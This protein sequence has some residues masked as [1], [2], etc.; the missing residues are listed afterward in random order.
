MKLAVYLNL[1]CSYFHL[2]GAKSK[3]DRENFIPVIKSIRNYYSTSPVFILHWTVKHI[4][5]DDLEIRH[6]LFTWTQLLQREGI[7]TITT[8]IKNI[9]VL[10]E[11]SHSLRPLIILFIPGLDAMHEF[12]NSSKS[13][14]MSSF[15]WLMIFVPT[16]MNK[17]RNYCKHP[18]KNLFNLLFDTE[19]LTMCYNDPIFREWYSVDG[20]NI[21]TYD[22]MKV[23]AEGSSSQ[24][25][26]MLTNLSL[27]ER[28]NNMKGRVQRA[29]I[30]KARI[31]TF[32]DNKLVGYL[33]RVVNELQAALNFTLVIAAEELIYGSYNLTSKSW[34]GAF[35]LVASREVDIGLAGF[36]MTNIRLDYVDYTVPILTTRNCLYLKQSEMMT[37]KWFAYY[38]TFSFTLWMS[39]LAIIIISPFI[40]ALIRSR[41][42]S[43]SITRGLFDEIVRVWGIFCQQGISATVPRTWSLRI[44]YFTLLATAIVISAAYS[45]SLIC[46]VTGYIHDVPIRTVDEFIEDGTYGLIV[47][48]DSSEYDMFVYSKD[49]LSKK[50]AKLLRPYDSLPYNVMDGF[51]S[52]CDDP[53]LAF[54]CGYNPEMQR[55]SNLNIPCK[56]YC[57]D[58]GRIDSL[59]LIL[60]KD[61]QYTSIFNYYLQKLL[62]SGVLNRYKNEVE[63]KQKTKFEAVGIFSVASV[64]VVFICG[65]VL[66]LVMVIV[67]M[68]VNS[69]ERSENFVRPF[70]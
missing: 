26:E 4:Q 3:F 23:H 7:A 70:D 31:L 19:M 50:L 33:S 57:V 47:V 35:R 25:I 55:R 24:T 53:K 18:P 37:V 14:Q 58:I 10:M 48:R 40:F 42:D 59:S 65:V 17:A 34:N 28:R 21:D 38:K 49:S 62:N 69:Y 63:F 11:R 5:Y 45:A 39:I 60:S 68:Y 64:L 6:L 54:Y 44:A 2:T 56:I 32:K 46:F 51:Q 41:V 16:P 1:I 67:E 15:V 20:V 36:S 27:H 12:S 52:V 66:S 8:S 29:V 30:I 13:L 61:N 9:N 22:L 43:T